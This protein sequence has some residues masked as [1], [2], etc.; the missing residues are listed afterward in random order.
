ML[1]HLSHASQRPPN[2]HLDVILR[3]S[4]IRPPIVLFVLQATIAAVKGLGTALVVGCQAC[5]HVVSFPSQKPQS[6]VWAHVK[7]RRLSTAG[8]KAGTVSSRRL[9][10]K[11]YSVAYGITLQLNIP[12]AL[13][14]TGWSFKLPEYSFHVKENEEISCTK[15][16]TMYGERLALHQILAGKLCFMLGT[17]NKMLCCSSSGV[18]ITS[19]YTWENTL[20][21]CS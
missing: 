15:G 5:T 18:V 6:L 1:Q 3:K 14:M 13:V 12:A 16:V 21:S 4:F 11:G 8:T 10:A 7:S 9:V 19:S 20:L 17:T 2:V